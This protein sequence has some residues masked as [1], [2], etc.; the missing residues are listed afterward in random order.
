MSIYMSKKW[1]WCFIFFV[2]T[3]FSNLKLYAATIK[4]CNKNVRMHFLTV[5][6][7]RN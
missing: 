6:T 3:T 4:L 7:L 5:N 1:L 2:K